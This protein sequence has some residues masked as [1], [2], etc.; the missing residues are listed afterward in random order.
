MVK[1]SSDVKQPRLALLIAEDPSYGCYNLNAHVV[2][3]G[4][5]TSW[6]KDVA[7]EAIRNAPDS[8]EYTGGLYLY[9]LEVRA[10]GIDG[11]G[12]GKREVVYSEPVVFK[13]PY[14]V[15]LR[16][17]RLMLKTLETV[18]RRLAKLDEQVGR[19]AT[20]G[21]FL[22]RV[23]R[24]VGADRFVFLMKHHGSSYSD[25]EYQF[26][27]IADG[28]AR[29]DRIAAEWVETGLTSEQRRDKRRREAAA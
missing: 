12:S 16:T 7:D 22:A 29:V 20:F 19:P 3:I 5:V 10:I 14:E 6:D 18:E 11:C 2:T 8:T 4:K 1:A 13:R 23:A 21:A 24:A 17:G 25:N 9:D 27:S 26:D 15:N 28:A